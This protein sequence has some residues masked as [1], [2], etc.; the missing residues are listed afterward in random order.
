M[1][2]GLNQTSKDK[3]ICQK[4][5]M[6]SPHREHSSSRL[7]LC[8]W[9]YDAVVLLLE[10]LFHPDIIYN[11]FAIMIQRLVLQIVPDVITQFP[12]LF[13]TVM[14]LQFI[15]GLRWLMLHIGMACLALSYLSLLSLFCLH[16]WLNIQL[17]MI[18]TVQNY[19]KHLPLWV[20]GNCYKLQAGKV[21]NT[22]KSQ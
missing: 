21:R 4:E 10:Q 19:I 18:Q 13:S 5:N 16:P 15:S 14:V 1:E 6:Q 22:V 8:C 3:P 20:S 12:D 7:N 17:S 9:K 2:T 11:D